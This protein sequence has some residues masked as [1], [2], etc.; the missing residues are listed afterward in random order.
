MTSLPAAP[1]N[2]SQYQVRFDWGAAGVETVATDVDVVVWV[3]VLDS[4]WSLP[5]AGTAVGAGAAAKT[6][7]GLRIE[8]SARVVAGGFT[9]R[10]AVAEWVLAR[11]AE[12]GD[13]FTVAVIASGDTRDDGSTRFAVEDLLAAGAIIDALAEV[14]IDYSSP[15]AAA[16]S[17]AFSGLRNAVGHL[18]SASGSGKELAAAGRTDEVTAVS[19]IDSST[20]VAEL[21]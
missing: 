18:V 7:N 20:N 16:A 10:T 14:G 15:E 17:A 9:N 1:Y 4:R 12:K 19:R 8:R 5:A 13:R 11:Q 3:D 2:Q 6:R 21:D